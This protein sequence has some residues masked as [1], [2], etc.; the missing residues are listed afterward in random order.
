MN[1]TELL[2]GPR[3]CPSRRTGEE[4]KRLS[5]IET[6]PKLAARVCESATTLRTHTTATDA[7]AAATTPSTCPR[8][9]PLG[10]AAGALAA[11]R[12]RPIC[13]LLAA[14]SPVAPPQHAH[15]ASRERPLSHGMAPNDAAS[16]SSPCH[17]L[18]CPPC[19]TQTPGGTRHR[20]NRTWNIP[21]SA[22]MKQLTDSFAGLE[23]SEVEQRFRESG[24]LQPYS[25]LFLHS[26]PHSAAAA[27]PRSVS[28]RGS[29]PRHLGASTESS[30]PVCDA[31]ALPRLRTPASSAAS[32]SVRSGERRRVQAR[33][34]S[35]EE[36]CLS[37]AR[38]AATPT[39][40][41]L[42]LTFLSPRDLARAALVSKEWCA[43][44]RRAPLW[45]VLALC[46]GMLV[47]W[48]MPCPR[49]HTFSS[50]SP[51]VVCGL[52]RPFDA[53]ACSSTY[54]IRHLF[55]IRRAFTS[56]HTRLYERTRPLDHKHLVF[57]LHC[58]TPR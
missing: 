28:S 20:H 42:V 23:E 25:E 21:S 36:L 11:D 41:G 34:F 47:V 4:Q 39:A 43:A 15:T 32:R 40:L 31:A 6:P 30:T 56:R 46:A 29:H 22:V 9:F 45:T 35:A 7:H 27:A 12:F 26:S 52:A 55:H 33:E 19:A 58:W 14:V 49:R 48:R 57:P 8:G 37:A 13:T 10:A 50:L 16:P 17:P 54:P 53:F 3:A 51:F 44:V 5:G 1:I 2:G 18:T 24:E 38:N